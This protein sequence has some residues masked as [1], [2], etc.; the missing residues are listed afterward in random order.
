VVTLEVLSVVEIDELP[1]VA[2][3]VIGVLRDLGFDRLRWKRSDRRD[4]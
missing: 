3:R 4:Y 1:M 2:R